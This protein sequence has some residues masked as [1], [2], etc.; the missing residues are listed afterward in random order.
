MGHSSY[1]DSTE[2]MILC[3]TGQF[4]WHIIFILELAFT[5]ILF[6][7]HKYK[8][9]CFKGNTTVIIAPVLL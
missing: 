4:D 5:S 8:N 7:M 3:N 1:T 2:C 6:T 9:L